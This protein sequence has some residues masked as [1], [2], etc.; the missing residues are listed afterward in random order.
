M[1]TNV[2][3][4]D[5][6]SSACMRQGKVPQRPSAPLLRVNA[7]AANGSQSEKNVSLMT[8]V[9]SKSAIY[10]YIFFFFN[11]IWAAC[12]LTQF[13]LKGIPNSNTLLTMHC[14]VGAGVR[15]TCWRHSVPKEIKFAA[16]YTKF[17]CGGKNLTLHVVVD[18]GQCFSDY[19]HF[20]CDRYQNYVAN[21]VYQ[22][23][24]DDWQWKNNVSVKEI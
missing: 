22:F 15:I 3:A 13:D 17:K 10:I 1:S 6:G 5:D 8:M 11:I 14:V 18:S 23:L 4:D 19:S 12:C 20:R 16:F 7:T 9:A 2:S 24:E 21:R